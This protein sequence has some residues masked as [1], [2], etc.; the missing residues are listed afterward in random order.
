ME[1]LKNWWSSIDRINIILIL[2]LGF[3][4]LILSFSIDEN[5]SINRHSIFFLFSIF[6]LIALSD[7][8]S[9][10]IRRISLFLFIIL[11]IIILLILFLDYEVK[12]AK[13]WF[14]IFNFTLQPSEIIK[15]I[16][17]ILTAWCI[18]KSIEDKKFYLP[19]LFVFFFLLISL[20]LMQPDLGMTVLLSATFFCQLFVAGLSIFLVIVAFLFI[21]GISIFSYFIFDHVQSRINSF[22]GGL[23]G[24]DTYQIDLSI[25][26]FKNG[27]L[28]G[29]GPGQGILKEKIPDANTDFIFAV[30]GEELGFIFCLIIIFIILSIIIRS[31][32]K[33]LQLEDPYKIIA[34]SGLICSFGL[35]CSINIFSSLGL[36]PTK[37]MTLPFV[38]YGGSSMISISILFGFLLSLTNKK[39]EEL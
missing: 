12:G 28:L 20:I 32:L 38:S 29:K 4:G 39:N 10:N 3:T 18:S 30:A 5:L 6:L 37:G 34:I 22:L 8:D 31:L 25:Q 13:R 35:Q 7:L 19:L 26:A 21:L 11:L 17:V 16:S 1:Y 27:G 33:V 15:P 23:G 2:S 24:T 9:K 14:Q 36:I